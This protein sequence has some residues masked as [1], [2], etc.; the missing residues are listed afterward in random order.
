[1]I[2]KKSEEE[3]GGILSVGEIEQGYEKRAV[4]SKSD[5]RREW[6]RE[7]QCRACGL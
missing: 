7:S 1:V 4:W 6:E 5:S 2:R 3:V